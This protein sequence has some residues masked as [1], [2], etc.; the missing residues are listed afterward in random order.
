MP[1]MVAHFL[2][3]QPRLDQMPGA[4]VPQAVGTAACPWSVC[5]RHV[6]GHHVIEP[7]G[8]KRPEGRPH[9]QEERRLIARRPRVTDIAA[10]G[11]LHAGFEREDLSM[12]TLGTDDADAVGGRVDILHPKPPNF[13]RP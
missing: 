4:G 7:T 2:E 3:G 12:P 9:G 8:G 13:A 5:G 11:V 6:R 10:D 1:Q